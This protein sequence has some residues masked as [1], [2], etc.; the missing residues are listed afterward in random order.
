[1]TDSMLCFQYL[2]M[3]NE[4]VW[5]TILDVKTQSNKTYKSAFALPFTSPHGSV[6]SGKFR[7][8]SMYD[9]GISARVREEIPQ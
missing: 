9:D 8:L 6:G 4:I 5:K 2:S 3:N 7:H 1:M